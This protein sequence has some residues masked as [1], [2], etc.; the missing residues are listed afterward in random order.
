MAAPPN[1]LDDFETSMLFE[2][3]SPEVEAN[4]HT[5]PG[6]L[7]DLGADDRKALAAMV[8]QAVSNYGGPTSAAKSDI[9]AKFQL[10]TAQVHEAMTYLYQGSL[11]SPEQSG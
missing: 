7:A 6:W 9:A 11:G 2:F 8:T 1:L 3:F 5:M 10:E 4:G